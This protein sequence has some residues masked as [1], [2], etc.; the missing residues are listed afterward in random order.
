MKPL[1]RKHTNESPVKAFQCNLPVVLFNFSAFPIK[2]VKKI[3]LWHS[4]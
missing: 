4:P 1:G 3:C 2:E